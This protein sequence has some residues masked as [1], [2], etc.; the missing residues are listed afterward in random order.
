MFSELTRVEAKPKVAPHLV[1]FRFETDPSVVLEYSKLKATEEGRHHSTNK[2]DLSIAFC[3]V[4]R[5]PAMLHV[6]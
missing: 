5:K 1:Q 6:I 4:F 3:A 2:I